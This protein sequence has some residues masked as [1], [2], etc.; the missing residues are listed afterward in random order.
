MS[1]VL[2]VLA[3]AMVGVL[4][5]LWRRAHQRAELRYLVEATRTLC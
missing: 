2:A 3:L 4:F 5:M 1:I